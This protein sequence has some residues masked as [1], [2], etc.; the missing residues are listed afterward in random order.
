MF[1]LFNN[2]SQV[3]ASLL[4]SSYV[5]KE[6]LFIAPNSSRTG[7]KFWGGLTSA[8]KE[9]H[10]VDNF[11]DICEKRV[12]LFKPLQSISGKS[13]RNNS[14]DTIELSALINITIEWSGLI[15]VNSFHTKSMKGKCFEVVSFSEDAVK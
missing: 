13:W 15:F 6:S 9:I 2:I 12:K 14:E 5:L 11:W 10:K 4:L 1:A 8:E 3:L 7:V